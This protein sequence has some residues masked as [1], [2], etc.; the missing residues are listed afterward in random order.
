MGILYILGMLFGLQ[1]LLL[2]VI[3][4][5]N[6]ILHRIAVTRSLVEH[7]SKWWSD[8]SEAQKGGIYLSLML[9]AFV[10]YIL[11]HH[12][13]ARPEYD[14]QA[15]TWMFGDYRCKQDCSGHQAGYDWAK[16]HGID[17]EDDCAGNSQSFME[18]CKRWVSEYQDYEQ[19]QANSDNDGW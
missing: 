6:Y 13:G 12:N 9:V 15:K 8:L 7:L 18:G 10:G 3:I 5:G 2:V 14:H 17:D 11:F 16:K 19:D 1:A 4:G